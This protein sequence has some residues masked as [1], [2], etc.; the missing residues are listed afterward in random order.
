MD[1]MKF[2]KYFI[3]ICETLQ[4]GY[5]GPSRKRNESDSGKLKRGVNPD[6]SGFNS[7]IPDKT[8]S[9]KS[10]HL[11]TPLFCPHRTC[12]DKGFLY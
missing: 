4:V 8:R 11:K 5:N 2:M 6:R 12:E 10:G 9:G 7:R 1:F 3:R